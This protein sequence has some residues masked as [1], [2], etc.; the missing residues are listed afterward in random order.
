[1]NRIDF[2]R[3]EF[4][5]LMTAG[6]VGIVG[7]AGSGLISCADV[8]ATDDPAHGALRRP[9]SLP[10]TGATLTAAVGM[11]SIGDG[12]ALP[13]W[14]FNGGLPGPTLRARTG[15]QARLTLVNGL[16]EDTIV[17]WHG[18]IVPEQADGHPKLAI[19][20]GARYDYSFPVVQ[21]AGTYW[22]HPHAHH[23]TASQIHRGLAGFFIVADAE[24]DALQLPG[25]ERDVLLMLQDR[26][27]GANP[28]LYAPTS[29]DELVGL[30][31][32]LPFGNGIRR[33]A[34]TV[35]ADRYRFRILNASHARV[36]CLALSNEAPLTVIGSDGGLL[37]SPVLVNRL[38]LGVGERTDILVDCS[39]LPVGGRLTL[40]SLPFAGGA[41]AD[42]PYPQGAA[43]DLLELVVAAPGKWDDPP[44]PLV[45]SDVPALPS[46][47]ITRDFVLTT[48]RD[49]HQIN[50]ASFDMLRI[51]AQIPLGQVE[52]WRFINDSSLPHPIHL[53]GT[54]FQIV[55]RQGG[56]NLVF[57]YETGWKDTALAMPQET[58][59]VLVRFD[60]YRGVF[61]LHCHNLQHEDMGM[62]LNIEVT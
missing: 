60:T 3:R 47:A 27:D 58:V 43:M 11:A 22:Y 7:G 46:S 32:D 17:H 5:R 16:A 6:V 35:T 23:K 41:I 48:H 31:G 33:P 2:N 21:R 52:R 36:Y 56:R 45:L 50:G 53:H 12:V 26:R 40:R 13:A 14:L 59:E 51:D 39:S 20:A 49:L 29:T 37:R 25:G 57:P 15:D 34:L 62:M 30:L 9:V 42:E 54:Q 8:A 44:L 55:S 24:E 19:G 28:L 10:V 61:P 18:L 4:V 1:M 38:F